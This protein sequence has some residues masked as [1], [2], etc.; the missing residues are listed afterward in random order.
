MPIIYIINVIKINILT[1][2]KGNDIKGKKLYFQ[3][4]LNRSN[5][6]IFPTNFTTQRRKL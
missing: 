3:N 4:K 1:K 6:N 5:R 2:E